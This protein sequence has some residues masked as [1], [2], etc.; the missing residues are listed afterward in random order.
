M[1]EKTVYMG[2]T[3]LAM[4]GRYY[5]DMKYGYLFSMGR[6]LCQD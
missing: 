5:D 4:A 2:K 6:F 3:A 1:R